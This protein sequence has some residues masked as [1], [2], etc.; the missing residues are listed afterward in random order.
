M[1]LI[2][3]VSKYLPGLRLIPLVVN[4]GG[5]GGIVGLVIIVTLI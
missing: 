1:V 3:L 4:G 2:Y 5:T